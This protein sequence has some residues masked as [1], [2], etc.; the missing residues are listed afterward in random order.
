MGACLR[1]QYVGSLI[2]KKDSPDVEKLVR[3]KCVLHGHPALL[4]YAIGNE[5]PAPLVRWLGR[6]RV[7]AGTSSDCTEPSKPRTRMA[8]VTYVNY[9]TTEYLQLPFLDSCVLQCLSGVAGAL[10]GYLARLQNIAGDRPLL[11]SEIGWTACATVRRPRRACSIAAPYDFCGWLCRAFV[12]AWTDE[13]IGV[14]PTSN[15]WAFA[16]PT[17]TGIRSQRLQLS[18]KAFAQVPFPPGWRCPVSRWS[19]APYNGSRTIRDCLEGL[20]QLEYPNLR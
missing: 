20:L 10:W 3:T 18:A 12:F 6:R 17:G 8:F 2:D 5:I 16:L 19:S 9:P 11:M 4:C 14:V 1:K 7:E 15:D 13:C